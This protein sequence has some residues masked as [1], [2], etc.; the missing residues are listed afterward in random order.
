MFNWQQ[1]AKVPFLASNPISSPHILERLRHHSSHIIMGCF[2]LLGESTYCQEESSCTLSLCS[3]NDLLV[4]RGCLKLSDRSFGTW[5]LCLVTNCPVIL[6]G[7]G[8]S[9]LFPLL[10]R[11]VSVSGRH[12]SSPCIAGG[13]TQL[14]ANGSRRVF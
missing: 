4:T 5:I 13:K 9:F 11:A 1:R 6:T 2:L 14:L 7:K 10:G 8:V 12:R 3:R